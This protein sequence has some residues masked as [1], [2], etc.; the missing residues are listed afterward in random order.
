MAQYTATE[1]KD[2]TSVSEVANWSDDKILLYQSTAESILD[3][4]NLDAQRT[5]YSTAYANAVVFLFDTLAQ[6][7]TGMRG[8]SKGK[9]NEQFSLGELPPMVQ[10]LLRPYMRGPMEAAKLVRRDMGLR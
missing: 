1:L 2:R 10:A 3:S 4:L 8:R 9:V 7:P 6:N 5:G